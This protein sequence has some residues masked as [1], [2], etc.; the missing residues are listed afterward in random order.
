[1]DVN[2]LVRMANQIAANFDYGADRDHAVASVSDHLARFWTLAMKRQIIDYRRRGET[3]LS[4]VADAAVAE[5]AETIGDA[6]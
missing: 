3:G 6:A 5:L 1:V 4:A 2:K